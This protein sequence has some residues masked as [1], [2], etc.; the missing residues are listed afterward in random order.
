MAAGEVGEQLRVGS[1]VVAEKDPSAVRVLFEQPFQ[2]STFRPQALTDEPAGSQVAA[3]EYGA[4]RVAVAAEHLRE[5]IGGQL[6]GSGQIED[7]GLEVGVR[8]VTE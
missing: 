3:G 6:R 8:E 2:G 1:G 5:Q 4:A 7:L